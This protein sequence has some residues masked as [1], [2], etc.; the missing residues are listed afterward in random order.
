MGGNAKAEPV[1]EP[2]GDEL[3]RAT[4]V[5]RP[6]LLN[7]AEMGLERVGKAEAAKV[8][9]TSRW[10]KKGFLGSLG[11]AGGIAGVGGA[12]DMLY[13][14]DRGYAPDSDLPWSQTPRPVYGPRGLDADGKPL[15]KVEQ[16]NLTAEE[17]VK[18]LEDMQ[19]VNPV[20]KPDWK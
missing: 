12:I 13:P 18:K 11:A 10:L 14:D 1:W 3:H 6:R 9:D 8:G 15:G 5:S 17:L 20:R 7:A 4:S 19:K 16:V 2:I